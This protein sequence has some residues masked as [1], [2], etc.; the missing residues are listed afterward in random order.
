M[1]KLRKATRRWPEDICSLWGTDDPDCRPKA[2]RE[3][4]I[5]LS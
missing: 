2:G 4:R 3:E 5:R 1:S